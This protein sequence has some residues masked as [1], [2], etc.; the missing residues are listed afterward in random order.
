MTSKSY[1]IALGA[2]LIALM[3]WSSVEPASRQDW[4]LEM[5]PVILF[6]ALTIALDRYLKLSRATYA[7]VA[8]YM[9]LHIIGAHYTYAQVPFGFVMR[10]WLGES[11]NMYDR[12]VHFGFG[13]LIF[14]PMREVFMKLTSVRG[15][16]SYFFPFSLTFSYAAMY[17]VLEWLTVSYTDASTG[18]MYL[19]AQ[20]DLWDAQKDSMMALVGAG[21]AWVLTYL[22]S[23]RRSIPANKRAE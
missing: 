20:G 14:Y 22:V 7:F 4:V 1:K 9:G 19:G 16:W 11:R 17:E 18:N 15:F 6:G 12:L 23:L 10:D 3:I 2:I 8:V 13:F 21:I 5:Y